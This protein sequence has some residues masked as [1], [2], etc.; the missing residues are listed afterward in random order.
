[1]KRNI[2]LLVLFISTITIQAQEIN[3][4]SID[5]AIELQKQNP[6]KI[7]IDVYTNWCGPCKALDR[8]TFH[9]KE[10]VDYV[11]ENYYAVKF[12][13]EG[14]DVINYK[15]TKY[16]NPKYDPARAKD[17][18]YSHEF[19]NFMGITAFPTIVFMDEKAEMIIPL[20]GYRTPQQL[21]LYLK[22]FHKD[23][24]NKFNSQEDFQAYSD[25]FKPE[26]VN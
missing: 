19:S 11:N 12:N 4:L 2:L 6:K 24:H 15:G 1:M 17:R 8:N 20:K 5:E 16:S 26:F 21:E 9:N 10:V 3:W 13:A 7:M 22:M 18:N 25:N 23:D 14:D